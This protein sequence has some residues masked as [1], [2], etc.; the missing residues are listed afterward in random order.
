M[1]FSLNFFTHV[2]PVEEFKVNVYFWALNMHLKIQHTFM[3]L[4]VLLRTN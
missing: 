2:F 1:F 3:K 4:T